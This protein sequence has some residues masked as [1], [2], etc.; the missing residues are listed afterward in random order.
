MAQW[1]ELLAEL[2]EDVRKHI[3]DVGFTSCEMVADSIGPGTR[4]LGNG[5]SQEVPVD[6]HFV[7]QIAKSVDTVKPA[8]PAWAKVCAKSSVV[9]DHHEFACIYI[10]LCMYICI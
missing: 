6:L 8:T 2:P 9:K 5:V 1:E 10:N 3:Q 4:D 7:E